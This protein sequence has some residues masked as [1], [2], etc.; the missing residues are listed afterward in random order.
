M[1][2]STRIDELWKKFEENPRRYFAPL[3]NEHRKA[4]DLEQAIAICQTHLAQQ[5]GHI[6]GHI[7]LAQALFEKGELGEAARVF[8]TALGLDPENL[9]ALRTMGDIARLAGEVDVARSWYER[10]LDVDPRNDEIATIIRELEQ[11]PVLGSD[12]EQG[13]EQDAAELPPAFE[14]VVAATASATMPEPAKPEPMP[15]LD[16]ALSME[17]AADVAPMG[18]ERS[19]ENLAPE[20]MP[21][22]E[23]QPLDLPMLEGDFDPASMTPDPEYA[24]QEST[25]V[26]DTTPTADSRADAGSDAFPELSD[27]AFDVG[28]VAD[29]H[30]EPAAAPSAEPVTAHHADAP[31]ASADVSFGELEAMTEDLG[32]FEAIAEPATAAESEWDADWPE[33]E[34]SPGVAPASAESLAPAEEDDWFAG[35]PGDELHV[36][37][38]TVGGFEAVEFSA[39]AAADIAAQEIEGFMVEEPGF[40]LTPA[41]GQP[42]IPDPTAQPEPMELATSTPEPAEPSLAAAGALDASADAAHASSPPALEITLAQPEPASATAESIEVAEEFAMPEAAAMTA[43]HEQGAGLDAPE[44]APEIRSDAAWL[45]P[46]QE[47]ADLMAM[48]PDESPAPDAEPIEP[49]QARTPTPA[50]ATPAIPHDA[51]VPAPPAFVTETMAELYLQ[52]GFREEALAVYRELLSRHPG[53]AELRARVA[54]LEAGDSAIRMDDLT[55]TPVVETGPSVRAFFARIAERRPPARAYGDAAPTRRPTPVRIAAVPVEEPAGP[56]GAA[57]EMPIS[58]LFPDA[59]PVR[60]G[61]ERAASTLAAAYGATAPD[62]AAT[63]AAAGELSLSSVFG[64]TPAEPRP[65]ATAGDFSFDQFFASGEEGASEHTPTNAPVV[66]GEERQQDIEQ[67]TAWLEGLKRK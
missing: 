37:A 34:A 63:R 51:V 10:V 19:A 18:A 57:V 6:S 26:A 52:Q 32:D 59:P 66:R 43:G 42:A 58:A 27:D 12:A 44:S 25:R 62:S 50:R 54:H 30:E 15:M 3:A 29:R 61:D 13:T 1:S 24:V 8:E 53:D 41:Y 36:D 11:A 16:D 20:R 55:G 21:E 47:S 2:S 48:L 17:P 60:G 23:L 40:H 4:G 56:A 35:I 28:P 65:A 33:N 14:P 67:F 7:V 22:I 38:E 64:D 9:I 31:A 46:E 49:V 5:P 45:T 39:E